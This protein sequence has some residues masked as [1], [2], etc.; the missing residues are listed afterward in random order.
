MDENK[1]S[2][3]FT[4]AS[5]KF[6]GLI[7]ANSV[8]GEPMKVS[9]GTVI[10]PISKVS[11]GFGGGGNEFEKKNSAGTRF[12]GGAGGGASVQAEAFL[13]INND[14]VRL[15]PMGG[16]SS[17][18]D[19]VID[20]VPGIIDKANGFFSSVSDKRAAKKAQKQADASTVTDTAAP[21]EIL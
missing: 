12:G 18:I 7:D 13:I 21:E 11:F 19:R 4:L 16:T 5:E 6:K 1:V 8:V 9:D 15:M 2:D 10:I 14:N 3:L 17:P 20:M